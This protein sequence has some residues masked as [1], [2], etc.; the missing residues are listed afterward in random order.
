M[1][2]LDGSRIVRPRRSSPERSAASSI[3]SA[4]RSFTEPV[5]FSDSSFANRRT[6]GAGDRC[7]SSTSGVLPTA[8]AIPARRRASPSSVVNGLRRPWPG[9][10][11]PSRHRAGSCR[12]P[13]RGGRPPDRR[14][15][16]RTRL[17]SPPPSSSFWRSPGYWSTSVDSAP[18]RSPGASSST[19]RAPPTSARSTGGSRTVTLIGALRSASRR[20][21]RSRCTRSAPVVLAADRALRIAT[22]PELAE[23]ASRARR[24]AAAGRPA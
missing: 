13:R 1:F 19:V 10:R 18:R 20:T 2:P 22:Q 5:G 24:N 4:T 11:S 8:E 21:A 14:R 15:R 23:R 6:P 17:R 3:A 7:A 16:S 9:E 12:G